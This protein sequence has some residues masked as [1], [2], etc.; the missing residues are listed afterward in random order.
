MTTGGGDSCYLTDAL[1][2]V[3]DL[4]AADGSPEWS[5]TYKPFGAMSQETQEDPGAPV[6]PMRYTGQLYDPDTG[7]YH[8]RARQYDPGLGR[9]LTVDPLEQPLTDP[10]QSAY[11][12]ADGVPTALVDPSGLDSDAPGGEGCGLWAEKIPFIGDEWC[13]GFKILSPTW[14]G[15]VG[16][17][18]TAGP[19]TLAVA[20]PAAGVFRLAQAGKIGWRGR[21]LWIGENW[22]LA[23]F[24]NKPGQPYARIPHYH[25]RSVDAVRGGPRLGQG[26][27]RHRPWERKS[28]DASVW[29]RF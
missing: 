7:L 2:S 10:Y 9:F 22:R 15:V 8:L 23:P 12:Y 11:L 26:L 5:H 27:K 17:T 18:L 20:V 3:A 16:A 1:G 25:R 6:N 14:Q 24:G 13:E 4:T 21:E 19:P 29:D 28:T